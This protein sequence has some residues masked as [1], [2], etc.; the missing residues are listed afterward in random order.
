[1]PI[2]LC[3]VPPLRTPPFDGHRVGNGRSGR[4]IRP[5]GIPFDRFADSVLSG[6]ENRKRLAF[7]LKH[8]TPESEDPYPEDLKTY[9][10]F[11]AKFERWQ[12]QTTKQA[13]T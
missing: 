13:E 10:T 12:Q 9:M 5:G 2:V 1:M 11:V 8:P 7:S 6:L 4:G 3:P